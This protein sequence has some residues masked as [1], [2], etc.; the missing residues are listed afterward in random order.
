MPKGLDFIQAAAI[1][2]AGLTAWRAL[3]DATNVSAGQTVLV[4]AAAGGVGL[5]GAQ[6]A[7]GRGARVIGT[8][9]A[10]NL[11]FLKEL[12]VDEAVDYTAGPF[13]DKI[14]DVDIVFDTV[15]GET[16]ER[17]WKTLKPGGVLVSVVQP[18]SEE[19]AAAHKAR[20]AFAGG[21]PPVAPV[22]MEIKGLVESGKLKPVV[23]TVL[24]L[25]EAARGHD[26]IAA[27]HTRGKIILQ[28]AH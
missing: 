23:S 8:A 3:V 18:P 19:S 1:P 9:S 26:L 6:L 27:G 16:Q 24:P 5:I 14:K 13:E 10:G 12:G 17:S 7:K 2:H 15:G 21:Y 25:S 28:P 11:A 22:L 4:H 20:G